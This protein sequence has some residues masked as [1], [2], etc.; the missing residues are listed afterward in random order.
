MDFHQFEGQFDDEITSNEKEVT[1]TLYVKNQFYIVHE[2]Y[3]KKL[4]TYIKP[5]K[6]PVCHSKS[7]KMDVKIVGTCIMLK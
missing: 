2:K 3:L 6:R 7:I 5:N 4:F 1:A